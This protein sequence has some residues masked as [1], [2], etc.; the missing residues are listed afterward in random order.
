[1]YSGGTSGFVTRN[2]RTVMEQLSITERELREREILPA[3][4]DVLLMVNKFNEL[5]GDK[6]SLCTP[7][8]VRKAMTAS[9]DELDCSISDLMDYGRE[10]KLKW[11]GKLHC[12]DEPLSERGRRKFTFPPR[13][14]LT[15]DE[16]KIEQL[17]REI[18]TQTTQLEKL[19]VKK[20]KL[21]RGGRTPTPPGSDVGE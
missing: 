12:S 8:P 21:T 18:E 7:V 4:Q 6:P 9:G 1:M 15:K 14:C 19:R 10:E 3:V 13:K 11:E 2:R 17:N 16:N 5:A 20:R